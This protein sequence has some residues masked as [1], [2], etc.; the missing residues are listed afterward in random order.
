MIVSGLIF[1]AISV[2]L[3]VREKKYDKKYLKI[4]AIEFLALAILCPFISYWYYPKFFGLT[5]NF[6][7][8]IDHRVLWIAVLVYY[9]G[10]IIYASYK[11]YMNSNDR[12]IKKKKAKI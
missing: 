7:H 6:I 2:V 9:V 11:A 10:R 4:Y 12:K 1:L 3:F 5:T 8:K